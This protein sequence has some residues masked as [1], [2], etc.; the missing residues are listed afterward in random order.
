[1]KYGIHEISGKCFQ[2]HDKHNAWV[3]N[4]DYAHVS[5]NGGSWVEP[6]RF[7]TKEELLAYLDKE[8]KKPLI[9]KALKGE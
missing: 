8:Y 1:M 7:K 9:I 5:L 6:Q 4:R 2:W 3:I